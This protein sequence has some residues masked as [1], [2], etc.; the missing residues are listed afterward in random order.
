MLNRVRGPFNVSLAA[1]AAGV[2]AIKDKEHI[3]RSKK[4][5][6]RL[7]N[8]FRQQVSELGLETHDSVG[9]FVLVNF[10]SG[11][12][13]AAALTFL[14]N[15]GVLVRG[16]SAYGLAEHIRIS[17]GTEDEMRVVVDSLTAFIN[18]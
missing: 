14:K 8:W 18:D 2:A 15:K 6:S 10:G 4:L 12:R 7:L 5:N 1:Q 3:T 17:I 13:A 9:N 16:M 11:E